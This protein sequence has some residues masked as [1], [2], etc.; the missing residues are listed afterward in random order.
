MAQY[1]KGFKVSFG[2]ES[3]YLFIY[4]TPLVT[5]VVMSLLRFWNVGLAYQWN[6]SSSIWLLMN[7][8][9]I[10]CVSC[11][12]FFRWCW[13][14][15]CFVTC[16]VLCVIN[17]VAC[18]FCLPSWQRKKQNGFLCSTQLNPLLISEFCHWGNTCLIIL[19]VNDVNLVAAVSSWGEIISFSFFWF[20][21]NK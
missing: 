16:I 20:T 3:E 17:D 6:C 2:I 21:E 12:V 18:V 13:Y 7:F 19:S 1:R 10:S 8:V 14:D 4:R 5:D 15:A 9:S 11:P